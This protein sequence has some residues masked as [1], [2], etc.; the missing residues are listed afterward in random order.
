MLRNRKIAVTL[1]RE[2]LEG[3]VTRGCLQ[4]VVLWLEGLNQNACFT[5]GYADAIPILISGK[6][7]NTVSEL[8]HKFCDMTE[9]R[10]LSIH[11]RW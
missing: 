11:K 9:L 5:P 1:A 10:S 7:L 6:F 3:S 8:L 4:G 2:S